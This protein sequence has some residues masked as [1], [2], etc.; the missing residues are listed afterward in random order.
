MWKDVVKIR[1]MKAQKGGKGKRIEN[2]NYSRLIEV[3][4]ER[5]LGRMKFIHVCRLVKYIETNRSM[6]V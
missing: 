6:T 1:K 2:G 3:S 5:T 4:V